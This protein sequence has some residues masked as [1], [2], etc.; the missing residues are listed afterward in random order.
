MQ[1]HKNKILILGSSG[2]IGNTISKYLTK[3]KCDVILSI[4]DNTKIDVVKK[5]ELISKVINFNALNYDDINPNLDLIDAD[6][7]INCIGITKHVIKKYG[8]AETY[9]L[10]S[11]LPNLL[12]LWCVKNNKK[13]IHIST[14]CIFDGTMP[15]SRIIVDDIYGQSKL[16]GEKNLINGLIIRTSTVG[17][18]LSSSLGLL[19]WFLNEKKEIKGFTNAFFNG[20]TTLTLS[21]YI[22]KILNNIP[23]DKQILNLTSDIISKYDLIKIIN[24]I[25]NCNK[26]IIKVNQPILDRSLYA[27]KNEKLFYV[28]KNWYQQILETKKFMLN[29]S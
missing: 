14:D 6:I 25:Y 19:D 29:N 23:S 9:F 4:S 22:Y 1:L 12:S 21:K 10:N 8:A 20:V 15:K 16:L 18:E 11:I 2:L 17:H 26:K 13:L 24:E 28:K 7:I 27:E 5:L 3:K